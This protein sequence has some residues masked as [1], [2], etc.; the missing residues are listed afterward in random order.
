M[1]A[2]PAFCL[3]HEKRVVEF[4]CEDVDSAIKAAWE[5]DLK[6]KPTEVR[7]KVTFDAAPLEKGDFMSWNRLVNLFAGLNEHADSNNLTSEMTEL[8][9]RFEFGNEIALRTCGNGGAKPVYKFEPRPNKAEATAQGDITKY[10]F[11]N[12]PQKAGVHYVSVEATVTTHEG[13]LRPSMRRTADGLLGPTQF[14]PV[15]DPHIEALARKITADLETQEA[16][17]KAVLKWLTPGKNIRF[18]GPVTGSR[19]GVRKVLEQGFGRCW[20]FCDCFV[21]LCRAAGV[22]C[23]Q[24]A[25]WLYGASGHIWA[26]ALIEG[27]GWQQVDPTGGTLVQCGIYHIPW[28]TSEDGSMPVL[29]V[30]LPRIELL[31]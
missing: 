20:D 4:V 29:Y 13:A 15:D 2:N 6:P 21:T 7:Y 25:G 31:N 18:K 1:K 30:S 14:W 26:E 19:Y 5:L 3:R 24:V 16:R 23:R 17:V 27:K 9:K 11:E 28:L 12:M 10:T 22:P 8:L